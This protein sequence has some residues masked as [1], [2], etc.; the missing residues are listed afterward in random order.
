MSE[1]IIAQTDRLT[2]R[3]F[4]PDDGAAMDR[5]YGDPE[6]MRFSSG[7]RS[8]EWVRQRFKRI[9]DEYETRGYGLWAVEERETGEVIGYCGL[10]SLPDVNGVPEIE[11]GYRLARRHW[12]LGYATESA[13][14]VRDVAFDC[15]KLERLIAL[16]DPL[17]VASIRVA[18]KLGMQYETD[19]TGFVTIDFVD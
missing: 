15:L 7:V 10:S 6:V 1:I 14:A 11:I 9:Q 18:E 8:P 17:N 19:F 4:N 16:I 2:L 12:G 13:L 5:V 3:H